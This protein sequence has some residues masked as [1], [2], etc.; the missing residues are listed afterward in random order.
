MENKNLNKP[1]LAGVI[2][3]PIFQSKSPMLH[4]F[5]LNQYQIN[6]YYIPIHTEIND[7][8]KTIT[9]L[10]SLGFRGVNVT[11]PFKLEMSLKPNTPTLAKIAISS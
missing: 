1:L 2:G 5:W 10:I 11:I 4:N 8:E 7:L 6:G 3:N 9:S